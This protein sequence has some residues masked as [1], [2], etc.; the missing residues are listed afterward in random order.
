MKANQGVYPASTMCRLLGVSSSGY[1]AWKDRPTSARAMA[2][3]AL[4]ERIRAIHQRSRGTYGMPRIHY[5]LTQD[6]TRIAR[7]RVARLMRAAGLQGVSRRKGTKTTIRGK[8]AQAIPDL[9][10]RNFVSAAPNQLWVA[11]ISVPQQAA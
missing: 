7:K 10:K 11:D 5:E 3:A 9:V 8:E 2:D 4:M 1:H 6:G